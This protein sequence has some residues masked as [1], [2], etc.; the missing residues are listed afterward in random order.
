MYKRQL[1][2]LLAPAADVLV[3][4]EPT[5]GSEPSW[6]GY[7]MTVREGAGVTRDEIVRALEENKVQTRMLFAGNMLR[8]PCF[9]G[10]R[11]RGE[12]FRVAGELANTDRIMNDAFWIGVYPGMTG[13]MLEF[14]AKVVL[15][16][17]GRG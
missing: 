8:Q 7:L 3:L 14:M 17:V 11:E 2:R 1:S 4:P 12:G 5:P 16:A 10:M 9:D 15:D 6:F 13:E